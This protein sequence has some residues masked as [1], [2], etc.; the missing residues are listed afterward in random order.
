MPGPFDD[1]PSNYLHRIRKGH[2]MPAS[3]TG[4]GAVSTALSNCLN[5]ELLVVKLKT[6]SLGIGPSNT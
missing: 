6:Y 5:H 1:I 3:I 4:F 2:V